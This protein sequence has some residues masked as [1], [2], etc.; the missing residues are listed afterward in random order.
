MPMVLKNATRR[1]GCAAVSSWTAEEPVLAD[2]HQEREQ[3]PAHHRRRNVEPVEPGDPLAELE[4]HE[5]E[6]GGEA[7]R[8]QQVQL[9]CS[10]SDEAFAEETRAGGGDLV[11]LARSRHSAQPSFSLM[12]RGRRGSVPP[13]L[14][15]AAHTAHTGNSIGSS[16][17]P[18][19]FARSA[20]S[21]LGAQA[22]AG[23]GADQLVEV[24]LQSV[25][26]ACRRGPAG[27]KRRRGRWRGRP[28]TRAQ[29]ADESSENPPRIETVHERAA[30]P[31]RA[32]RA[33]SPASWLP[34]QERIGSPPGRAWSSSR[35]SARS[36]RTPCRRDPRAASR[37]RAP[38]AYLVSRSFSV[39]WILFRGL[40]GDARPAAPVDERRDVGEGHRPLGDAQA[41][42]RISWRGPT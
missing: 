15:P 19:P 37:W 7:Q 35:E 5:V 40:R 32:G 23:A 25:Q 10:M 31:P 36:P 13:V 27:L 41:F 3:Q 11:E 42:V 20:G 14:E 38:G 24:G 39:I 29:P 17:V 6:H 33:A 34:S 28:R 26:I 18:C 1:T 21:R 30:A 4:A 12:S 2:Q 9:E 8:L 16:S 22:L